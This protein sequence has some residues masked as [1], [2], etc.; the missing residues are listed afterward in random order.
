MK[1]TPLALFLLA[2]ATSNSLEWFCC[3]IN[4]DLFNNTSYTVVKFIILVTQTC[5]VQWRGGGGG[6][7]GGGGGEAGGVKGR[8]IHPLKVLLFRLHPSLESILVSS[9]R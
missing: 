4:R 8:V 1:S 3:V 6:G 5:N 7:V 2:Y 9:G